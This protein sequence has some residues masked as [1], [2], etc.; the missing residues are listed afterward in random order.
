MKPNANKYQSAGLRILNESILYSC[1]V[2]I[3]GEAHGQ[4]KILSREIHVCTPV[5]EL[6][7]GAIAQKAL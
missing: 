7:K 2:S 5:Y 3:H 6:E 4:I 1:I